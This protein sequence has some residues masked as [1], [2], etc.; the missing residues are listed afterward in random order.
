MELINELTFTEYIPEI[1]PN[2]MISKRF[3]IMYKNQRINKNLQ[4][5]LSLLKPEVTGK[6]VSMIKNTI[7]DNVDIVKYL[8][9]SD[10]RMIEVFVDYEY[11]T[12]DDDSGEYEKQLDQNKFYIFYV[13]EELYEDYANI[14]YLIETKKLNDILEGKIK[15]EYDEAMSRE[16]LTNINDIISGICYGYKEEYIKGYYITK[17]KQINLY[18]CIQGFNVTK[19][20]KNLL[21]KELNSFLKSDEYKKLEKIFEEDY[22][23]ALDLIEDIRDSEEFDKIVEENQKI[24]FE[25]SPDYILN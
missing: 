7:K 18:G 5:I 1:A 3:P 17:N 20:E 24:T 8:P 2:G 16:G 10:I 6:Y 11:Y 19:D 23:L 14:I 21:F 15:E 12:F 22:S 25:C 9:D 4:D 13:D